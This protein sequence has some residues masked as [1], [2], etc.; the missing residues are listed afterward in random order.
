MMTSRLLW[1]VVPLSLG[2]GLVGGLGLSAGGVGTNA[3]AA[4]ADGA[5][6]QASSRD[7]AQAVSGDRTRL[8]GF[9]VEIDGVRVDGWTTITIPGSQTAAPGGSTTSDDLLL[10]RRLQPGDTSI[11]GWREATVAGDADDAYRDVTISVLDRGGGEQM[12][13]EFEDAWV[14]A[15]HPIELSSE[16][17]GLTLTEAVTL[18]YDEMSVE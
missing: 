10:E 16:G 15:Y 9:S 18:D 5:D 7:L 2:V 11:W 1:A 14:K 17:R 3:A 12:A 13:W 8:A 6:E 4:H